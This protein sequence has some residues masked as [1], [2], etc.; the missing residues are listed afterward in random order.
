MTVYLT[1]INYNNTFQHSTNESALTAVVAI[2]FWIELYSI[3]I[4]YIL[5]K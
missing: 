4:E 5:L 1:A 2:K 3:L